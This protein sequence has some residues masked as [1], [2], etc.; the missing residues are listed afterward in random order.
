M[1]NMRKFPNRMTL[2]EAVAPERARYRDLVDAACVWQAG[3][4]R[5]IDP[6]LFTLICIGADDRFD[7][8]TTPVRWTRVAVSGI[9]R[10]AINNWCVMQGCLVPDDV[11]EAMWEWFE[12]LHATGRLHTDSDPLAELRKPLACI[13]WLDEQGRRLPPEADRVVECE[14]FLPYRETAELPGELARQAERTGE[15]VLD[16]LRRAVGRPT[17]EAARPWAD[18]D[19]SAY[20]DREPYGNAARFGDTARFGDDGDGLDGYGSVALLDW[21][22][23]DSGGWDGR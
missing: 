18:T 14:C 3:R 23:C 9:A 11:P 19:D 12:F 4:T 7:H 17:R 1:T 21:P 22:D 5:Q 10:C 13:G 20:D 8:D 6:D 15:D 16:A 2:S